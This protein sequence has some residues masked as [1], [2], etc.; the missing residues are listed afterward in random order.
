MN[1]SRLNNA[2]ILGLIKGLVN[3]FAGFT[4]ELTLLTFRSS[5]DEDE[6][7]PNLE[8]LEIGGSS[9][10]TRELP[11]EWRFRSILACCKL[12]DS[13]LERVRN[14]LECISKE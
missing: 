1:F 14:L 10:T 11:K 13:S 4:L 2:S 5:T 8:N 3:K 9:G 6:V 12:V 7:V